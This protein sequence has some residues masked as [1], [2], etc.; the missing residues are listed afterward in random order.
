MFYRPVKSV[1]QRR[2]IAKASS[3]ISVAQAARLMAKRNVGAVMVVDDGRLVGIISERDIV[4][5]VAAKGLDIEATRVRDVMT[6]SPHTIEPNVPFGYALMIMHDKG[7]RHLPVIDD[8]QLVGIVSARSAMD[9]DLEEFESEAQRRRH[10][11]AEHEAKRS[12]AAG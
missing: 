10:F 9:P 2:S 3:D 7:F 4:F 6:T 5:R 11:L 12:A 8:G 1:M